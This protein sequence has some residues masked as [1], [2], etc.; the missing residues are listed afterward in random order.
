MREV[1]RNPMLYYF[2]APL[3][4]AV[5]PL[6]VWAVYPCICRGPRRTGKKTRSF[7]TKARC[8]S[9]IFSAWTPIALRLDPDR[10]DY[11]G[12]SEVSGEFSYAKEIDRVA[13][14][15]KIPAG[16]CD[17]SAGSIVDSG[18]KRKQQARVKLTDVNIVQAATFLSR[19]QSTW[20]KLTCDKVKLTK[21][22]G[23]PDQ[24]DVD[25]TFWYYY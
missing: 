1:Y 20:V 19:I 22:K 21:D 24:W 25:F 4:V 12:D 11:A 18:N 3:L 14:L 15:C 17:Y 23:L 5:W 10:L 9:W 8:I 16:K 6:L 7:S 13:T 2:L